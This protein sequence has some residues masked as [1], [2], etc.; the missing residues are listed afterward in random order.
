MQRLRAT[1]RAA[2]LCGDLNISWRAQDVP[3]KLAM[4]PSAR[5]CG[6]AEAARAAVASAAYEPQ[7]ADTP[8]EAASREAVAVAE[9]QPAASDAAAEEDR[10]SA[11]VAGAA[12]TSAAPSP[13]DAPPPADAPPLLAALFGALGGSELPEALLRRARVPIHDIEKEIERREGGP[14]AAASGSADGARAAADGARAAG[15]GGGSGTTQTAAGRGAM[16]RQ[17]AL[18]LGEANS[19]RESIDWLVA[20][21]DVDGYAARH[22]V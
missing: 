3:W 19:S 1:G 18:E 15:G 5:L 8:D 14:S 13:L 22:V 12:L 17:L 6:L 10:P 4:V 2:V 21:L 20:V 11:D 16:L 7:R 9:E